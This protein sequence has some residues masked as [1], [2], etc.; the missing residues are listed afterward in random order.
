MR[1]SKLIALLLVFACCCCGG[2]WAASPDLPNWNSSDRQHGSID[3]QTD[4]DLLAPLGAGT[5]NAGEWLGAFT[6]RGPRA[7]DRNA[8]M[9]MAGEN[10]R[11]LPA[12]HPLLIEAEHWV[13]QSVM[14]FYPD[15]WPLDGV[16]T[17]VPPLL[18]SMVLAR[19]WIARGDATADDVAALEDYRRALRLGRLLRQED[20][21][22]I[23]DIVGLA[24]IGLATD[25]IYRRATTAG[26]HETALLAAVAYGEVAPLRI[27]SHRR[28][29]EVQDA[30]ELPKSVDRRF[31]LDA[32]LRSDGTGRERLQELA[33]SDD[34]YLRTAARRLLTD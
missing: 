32:L 16:A 11:V 13:D 21:L 15:V 18:F 22:V 4:L 29:V 27:L 10:G 5:G 23:T 6:L 19:S 28:L 26:D 34:W 24:A 17:E 30:E 7:A 8:A 3:F 1:T 33:D 31:L 20:A 12:D 14:R 9:A 2:S 25:A